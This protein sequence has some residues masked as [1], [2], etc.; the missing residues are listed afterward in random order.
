[1]FLLE[2]FFAI[3]RTCRVEFEPWSDAVQIEAMIVV[4]GQ[5]NYERVFVYVA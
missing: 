2:E 5:S 1:M 3:K 4:A